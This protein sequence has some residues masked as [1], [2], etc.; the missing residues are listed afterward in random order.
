MAI[1]NRHRQYTIQVVFFGSALLLILKALQLQVLDL[2]FQDRANAAVI[3]EVIEYPSRGVIFDRNGEY[4]VEND[5]SYDLMVTYNQI[6][7]EMDTQKFVRLLGIDTAYFRKALDKNWRSGKYSKSVPFVFLS[8]ISPETFGAFSESLPEFPGFF[9]QLRNVRDY[10]YPNAAH[11]LGYIREVNSKEIKKYGEVYQS[12]DYIGASGLELAYEDSLRGEKGVRYVLKDNLG[13]EFGKYKNG[14]FNVSP[15]SGKDLVSTIDIDLQVYGEELMQ[16]KVGSIVAIQPE[17]GEILAMVSSP[18]YN[19]NLLTINKDRGKA[20]AQLAKDEHKP[21]FDRSVMAQYPPGSLFKPLV[22]LVAM[23]E[24]VLQSNRTIS[25]A[26]AYY[27]NGIRLTGCHGHQ[28]C[29]NVSKGIQVS[30][31][32]YFVTV[33]RDVVDKYGFYNPQIGLDTFNNYLDRFG[34][35]RKLGLDFPREQK[36]NYPSSEYYNKWFKGQRWNSIWIRSLG[37]G[38]GEMLMTNVQMA[39]LASTLANRGYYYVPHLIKGIREAD[40]V[41][42]EEPRERIDVGIDQKYFPTVIDGMELVVSSGTAWRAYLPDIKICGKTGTAENNQNNQKDHSIFMAFAPKDKPE[43]AIA[44]YVENAGAGGVV[45]A[46]I[47]SLMIEK[48]IRGYIS[49][50]RVYVE[51]QMKTLNLIGTEE[52]KN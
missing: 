48:Y 37:I 10:P 28:T 9:E 44:V 31:N 33:F 8:K 12:G 41:T 43:I 17:T 13:R 18:T 50:P 45:A 4:L 52:L 21:F 35:G 6:D 39:N 27:F 2:S 49:N 15:V 22:A 23:Q 20:Y 34:I 42:L 47:A 3:D 36:G 16:N 24:G 5:A 7:P 40:N 14:S 11:V 25:C 29:T 1:Q 38:Q 46:P 19:P 51:N 26:G 30:C 32:A